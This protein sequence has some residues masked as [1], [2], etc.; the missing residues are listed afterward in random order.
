MGFDKFAWIKATF[1]D[2]QI[3]LGEKAILTYCALVYVQWGEDTFCVRQ[4]TIAERCATSRQTVNS[5]FRH[6]S[7]RGF[8]VRS[9]VRLVGRGHHGGDEWRL[10]YPET[11]Q[12]SLHDSG[13]KR[14]K[15]TAETC[16]AD[17][18]KRVKHLD[19]TCKA[20]NSST[21]ENNPLRVFKGSLEGSL[22][23]SGV[24]APPKPKY[25][26]RKT[27]ASALGD[28]LT[29][30]RTRPGRKKPN[31]PPTATEPDPLAGLS[32][33]ARANIMAARANLDDAERDG[34]PA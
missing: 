30:P 29:D 23:G 33:K 10:V 24:A 9:Q 6:A 16:K 14:V 15:Q 12:E 3:P 32:P 26:R 18:Q 11:C 4:K 21:S 25:Q 2:P 5:A 19:E 7:K 17:A 1:A 20:A 34:Q 27:D 31:T 13:E 22:E 28:L 8:L